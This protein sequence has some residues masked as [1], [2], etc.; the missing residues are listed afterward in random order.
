M[1]VSHDIR[2]PMN[3]INGF[4]ELLMKTSLNEE[5]EKFCSII[6]RKGSG[7][8]RLIEDVIDI[9]AVEKG[10]IRISQSAFFVQELIEDLKETVIAQI[11]DRNISFK[12]NVASNVPC[13]LLGD[14][15]RL[16]QILENLCGNAVKYTDEGAIKLTISADSEAIEGNLR[17]IRFSVEDTG[18]GIPEDKIQHIFE[19]YS[20]FH[21]LRGDKE[22]DGV[23]MGLHIVHTL[24]K[25]MDGV[26]TVESEVGKGSKFLFELGMEEAE[27][28]SEDVENDLSEKFDTKVNLSGMNILIAEDDE[29]SRELMNL[30]L[31]KVNCNVQFAHDGDEVL[32]ELKNRKYDLVLMDI[33]MPKM[34]GFKTT[35]IIRREIDKVV[36]IIAITAHVMDGVEGKCKDV[37]MSGYIAKP[38][39]ISR[40]KKI[41]QQ[42]VSKK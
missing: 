8:I 6:K 37:G 10:V 12:C 42:Y 38:V 36:P 11:G 3:V 27:I 32:R 22:K 20:R 29:D 19:P 1:N 35:E 17:M 5:Q 28:A 41:I 34:D 23:G 13:Q 14:L 33:R 21:E 18:I 24:I 2:T 26:I 31:G 7:L 40:L 39:D 16:R 25:E 30:A 4:N 9:A 15:M